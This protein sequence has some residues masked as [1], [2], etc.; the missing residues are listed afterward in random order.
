MRACTL[1]LAQVRSRLGFLKLFTDK[2]SEVGHETCSSFWSC[3]RNL[4]LRRRTA[5]FLLLPDYAVEE[6]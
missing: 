4:N 6:W 3:D 5:S 1:Y 2:R